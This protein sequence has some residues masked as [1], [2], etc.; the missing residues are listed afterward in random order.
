MAQFSNAIAGFGPPPLIVALVF[1]L[2][3]L[4]VG[5]PVHCWRGPASRD[6]LGTLAGVFAALAYLTLILS[7]AR[8]P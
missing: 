4:L 7:V 3:Y 2:A 5:I 8:H 1:T 6:V